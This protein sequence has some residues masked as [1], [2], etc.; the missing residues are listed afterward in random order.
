MKKFQFALMCAAA[1]AFVACKPTNEPK[2][3]DGGDG[4]DE[5]EAFVSPISVTDGSAAEWDNLPAEYVFTTVSAATPVENRSALKSVKVY[6]DNMYLN[7][8]VEWDA[9]KI[10][11]KSYVPFHIYIDADNS[12]ATGG[13]ADE[14]LVGSVD[15]LLETAII[16]SADDGTVSTS[17]NPAVFKWWGEVGGSGWN[18]TDPATEHSQEDGW[19]AEVAEGS[20]PIGTSQ[21]ISDNVVEIQLLRELIPFS[22]ANEFKIGFDIQQNWSSVGVLPNANADETGAEVKAALMTVKTH[23]TE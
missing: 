15:V 11:D 21:I 8:L 5:E 10:T 14:F 12:D 3:N 20:L 6:N 9:T 2:P 13:Y 18:W 4:D 16:S 17:Y 22:I 7:L 19:G 1:L 23:V